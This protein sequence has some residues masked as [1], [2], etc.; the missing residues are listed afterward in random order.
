MT[1]VFRGRLDGLNM[2][3]ARRYFGVR[4]AAAGAETES[5]IAACAA[6]VLAVQDLRCCLDVFPVNIEGNCVD[7][8]FTRANSRSLSKTLCGCNRA[9][10]FACTAG[11]GIDR[12]L[13]KYS[14]ISPSKAAAVQAAGAALVEDWCDDIC[15]RIEKKYKKTRPRFSCGYGDLPL[16]MQREI[17]SA[18]SVTANIGVTL[19]DDCFMTPTK[20]VTAIV[21]VEGE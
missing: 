3:E 14:R 10:V 12:L 1:E 15:R 4:G 19:S 7:L 16:E 9:V 17:F 11:V 13:A 20:S 5:L 8:G 6:E 2:N 18:L 21:G